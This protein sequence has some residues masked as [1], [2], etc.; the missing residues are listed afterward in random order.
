MH[1]VALGEADA[2][3]DQ[4]HADVAPHAAAAGAERVPC[5]DHAVDGGDDGVGIGRDGRA[6]C[7]LL[8]GSLPLAPPPALVVQS[9]RWRGEDMECTIADCC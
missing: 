5:L 2:A 7:V 4:R 1:E 9:V 6:P 3:F 8:H